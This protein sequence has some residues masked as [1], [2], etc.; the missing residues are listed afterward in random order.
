LTDHAGR[1]KVE[2]NEPKGS[3]LSPTFLAK[4]W[5]WLN[6]FKRMRKGL[7]QSEFLKLHGKKNSRNTYHQIA[8]FVSNRHHPLH[9]INCKSDSNCDGIK[10]PIKNQFQAPFQKKR[11]HKI[12]IL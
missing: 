12:K 2:P 5:A 9:Y 4:Y 8:N 6:F 7:T 3:I 1:L 11:M 10:I